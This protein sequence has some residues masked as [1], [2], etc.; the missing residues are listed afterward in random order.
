[1]SPQLYSSITELANILNFEIG[2][3]KDFKCHCNNNRKSKFIE[4]IISKENSNYRRVILEDKNPLNLKKSAKI[5][6]F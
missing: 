4:A 3:P 6:N 1:M 2:T 5:L